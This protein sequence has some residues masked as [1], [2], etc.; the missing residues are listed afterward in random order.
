MSNVIGLE[1]N[2]HVKAAVSDSLRT[3][4]L[5]VVPTLFCDMYNGD[6]RFAEQSRNGALT[7]QDCKATDHSLALL[8]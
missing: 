8:C 7:R 5:R 1:G 4:K 3:T 6:L 2:K